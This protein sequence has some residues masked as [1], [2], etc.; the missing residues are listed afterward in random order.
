VPMTML[1]KRSQ[2]PS[3]L[4]TSYGFKMLLLAIGI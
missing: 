4:T 3:H 2:C 1:A